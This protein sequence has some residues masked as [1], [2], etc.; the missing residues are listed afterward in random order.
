MNICLKA[1]KIK[2]VLSVHAQMVFNFLVCLVKERRKIMKFL[3]A[4]LK[5][6]TNSKDCSKSRFEFMF[7]L[8]FSY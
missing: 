6:L 3:L 7:W 8:S 2:T 4:S 5:T 1:Y